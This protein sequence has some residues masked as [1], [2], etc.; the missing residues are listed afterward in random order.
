MTAQPPTE[1]EEDPFETLSARFAFDYQEDG[2]KEFKKLMAAL[3]ES[4]ECHRET[5]L[6]AAAELMVVRLPKV[7][8]LVRDAAAKCPSIAD[9]DQCWPYSPTGRDDPTVI[10]AAKASADRRLSRWR[11]EIEVLLAKAGLTLDWLSA[12]KA[13]N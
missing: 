13:E 5:L 3:I 7:A 6:T 4:G 10:K 2:T 9:I 1:V 12:V 11:K 8:T